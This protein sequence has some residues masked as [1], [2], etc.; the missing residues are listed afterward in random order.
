MGRV[1]LGLLGLFIVEIV[2]MVAIAK[3]AGGATTFLALVVLCAA[4][5][6]VVKRQGLATWRRVNAGFARGEMP[7]DALVDAL[8]WVIAGAFLLFPG[9]VSDAIAV[10]LLLPPTRALLRPRIVAWLRSRVR[11]TPVGATGV[12]FSTFGGGTRGSGAS[13]WSANV[14]ASFGG[15]AGYDDVIDVDGEEVFLDE[16]RG[17]LPPGV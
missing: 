1:L 7:T 2:L 4:G 13:W 15:G 8:I 9:F 12:R 17:E 5:A 14:G 3:A 11:S 10:L 6:W 16:P